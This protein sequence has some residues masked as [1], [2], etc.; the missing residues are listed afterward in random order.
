MHDWGDKNVDWA[1]INQCAEDIPKFMRRWGRI[2]VH[3]KE[4]WGCVRLEFLYYGFNLNTL[5]YP[6]FIMSRLPHWLHKL[7]VDMTTCYNK[8]INPWFIPYQ[9]WITKLALK[10]AIKKYPHLKQEILDGHETMEEGLK[11]MGIGK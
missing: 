10:R 1:G 2:C 9:I 7:D 5:F 4:K 8:V 3:G 11:W 6:G